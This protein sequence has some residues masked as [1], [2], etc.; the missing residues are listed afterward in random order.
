MVWSKSTGH[1][2]PLSNTAVS[3]HCKHLKQCGKCLVGCTTQ[4]FWIH[5]MLT[6]T[7]AC[8]EFATET[9]DLWPCI[10]QCVHVLWL[11]GNVSV[12]KWWICTQVA[13]NQSWI[14]FASANFFFVFTE[15]VQSQHLVNEHCPMFEKNQT[16]FV[17]QLNVHRV[18]VWMA[19]LQIWLKSF[20]VMLHH[21]KHSLFECC[22]ASSPATECF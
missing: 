14:N 13:C 15:K 12:L 1:F 17:F 20:S 8:G 6:W 4:I 3:Q 11:G 9:W 5:R 2:S 19:K 10:D 22:Q 7:I 18:P 21:S 16:D